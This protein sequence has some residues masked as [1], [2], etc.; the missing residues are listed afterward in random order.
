M[1]ISLIG[2]WLTLQPIA[3]VS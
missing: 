1:L 3:C 2:T